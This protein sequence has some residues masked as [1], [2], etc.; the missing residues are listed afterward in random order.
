MSSINR[1]LREALLAKT[2]KRKYRVQMLD[3]TQKQLREGIENK[4][5]IKQHANSVYKESRKCCPGTDCSRSC[6]SKVMH[7]I[8][9]FIRIMRRYSIKR[10]LLQDVVAGL[11]VGIM[12][13]PQGKSTLILFYR[14]NTVQKHYQT[15]QYINTYIIYI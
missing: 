12:H 13:I 9:P 2:Q 4:L 3:A 6:A 8:F 7:E 15:Q 5:R 10:N 1:D 14:C 11:T